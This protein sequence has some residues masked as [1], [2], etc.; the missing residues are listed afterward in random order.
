M[1]LHAI[2][3]CLSYLYETDHFLI[4]FN[5]Q[6]RGGLE[7]ITTVTWQSAKSNTWVIYSKHKVI[8]SLLIW[9]LKSLI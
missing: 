7:Q 2:I 9:E 5:I 1:I 8:L 4:Q 6:H 3:I